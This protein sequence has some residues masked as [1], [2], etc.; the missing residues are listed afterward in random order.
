MSKIMEYRKYNETC[1][2]LAEATKV[3]PPRH[4]D[5]SAP[6]G[7]KA[8]SWLALHWCCTEFTAS[9]DL[10]WSCCWVIAPQKSVILLVVLQT[11]RSRHWYI[12]ICLSRISGRSASSFSVQLR[13]FNRRRQLR[14]PPRSVNHPLRHDDCIRL[15]PLITTTR[16]NR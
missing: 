1:G 16:P 7:S 6:R 8:V 10:A 12:A 5:E 2:T 9:S 13:S 4:F 14:A 15:Q 3:K 11:D